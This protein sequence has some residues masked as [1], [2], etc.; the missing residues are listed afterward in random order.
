MGKTTY[1]IY[2][3]SQAII[4]GEKNAKYREAKKLSYT[5]IFDYSPEKIS[6][7]KWEIR[8]KIH[9]QELGLKWDE[10][11]D[12]KWWNLVASYCCNDVIATEAVFNATKSYFKGRL[13]LCD[14]AN[15][16]MG[17]G[18]TPNDS[19]NELT[20][21]LIVGNTK[22]PQRYYVYPNLAAEFPGYEFDPK[23][24]DKDRYISKDVIISGKSFYKGY[25]PG[26]GGFVYAVPGMYGVSESWDSAS[27]HPSSIIAENGFGEF[28]KN[29]KRLLDLRLKVKHKEYDELRS[30]YDGALA[31][32][33]ETDEDAKA[34]SFAL[35][36]A[37]NSVYGL[38][39][40]RFEHKLKDPRNIDNWVAKRGALFMID[41]MLN[42]REM[43]YT[44]IHCKT[45]SIKVL[46]PDDRV[47]NY[48]RDYG[49]KYGYTFELEHRFDRICLVNDA[50]YV[51]KFADD[52]CNDP[53]ERGKW[54]A[55]GKQFQVPYVFKTLFSHEPIEFDDMCE[56][57]NSSTA[58]YLDFDENLPEGEHDYQF[59]GKTG[60]FCPM[61]PG[62]GGGRL[63]RE[64]DG[65]YYAA[66]STKGYRFLE[67][68]IVEKE[69][70]QEDIDRSYYISQ[71]D[72]AVETIS[73]FGDFERFVSD[74]PFVDLEHF[75][76][77]PEGVDEEVE[78]PWAL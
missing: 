8:L 62:T 55:T 5:D 17:P 37:I 1:E 78:L 39:A 19:T 48:I 53:E 74:A 38:T 67:A 7:K 4:N 61:K 11:V 44:V 10:P 28:T 35:K 27:H 75:M 22:N 41:L 56:T 77:V 58:L 76:N 12:P 33:L 9:H 68:E 42:V 13:I 14:L 29:F 40:A 32:Y 18:S 49:K 23:G 72:K 30:L 47:R 24:I 25:D 43:G 54:D 34:L 60:L 51:C 46:N 65:K 64:K 16:L 3:L 2:L 21:K 36:I 31:K 70:K 45:D 52:E 15:I 63:L 66:E 20:T 6:L 59:V 50:V 26:E 71:V 69:G 73:K 57:K